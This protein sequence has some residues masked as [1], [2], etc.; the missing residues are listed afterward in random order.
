MIKFAVSVLCAAAVA[1]MLAPASALAQQAPVPAVN[2]SGS[3]A[4]DKLRNEA[5][6][7]K[8]PLVI[9][10]TGSSWCVYCN[11]FTDKHI[12][13]RTF[14][15]ASGKKFIFWMVDTRQAPG[16]TPGSFTFQFVP[17]EAGKVVGCIGSK[18]P[19][20]VFGPPAVI[21]LDPVSGKMIK[22][23]V[24]Q[25]DMDKEGKSLPVVIEECWKNFQKEGQKT[26]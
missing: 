12:K 15:R 22:K 25:G 1:G 13:E 14:K 26:A 21:I 16:R 4:F 2:E 11:I 19:Y 7:K 20:V 18:A 3:P 8:V 5:I 24:S 10:L 9:Y 6:A 23:M 17:E